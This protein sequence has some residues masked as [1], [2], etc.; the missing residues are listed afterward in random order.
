[1]DAP[2]YAIDRIDEAIAAG[3]LEPRTG[4]G[5]PIPN[6]TRDPDWWVR[7][8]LD[9]ERYAERLTEF[10]SYRTRIVAGAVAA[11]RLAEARASITNLN[12]VLERWNENAPH[13]FILEPVSEIW[14]ITERAR[15]PGR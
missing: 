11:E 1:M 10:E 5:E 8:L 14:L 6:L 13:G 4:S 7:A 9:R 2:R 3:D 12:H 15:A